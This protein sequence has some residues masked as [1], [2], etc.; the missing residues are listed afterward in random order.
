LAGVTPTAPAGARRLI[1]ILAPL[2]LVV[3]IGAQAMQRIGKP[4]PG[5]PE[6]YLAVG[7]A[8][9]VTHLLL[10]WED[11]SARL[12]RRQLR[13]GTNTL[14][15]SLVVLGILGALNYLVVRHSKRFDLTKNKRYSLSDQTKKVLGG[16]KQDVTV[17]YFQRKAEMP[18]GQDRMKEYT[19][20]S[21]RLKVQFVDPVANPA[22]AQALDVRGPWPTL[23]LEM[24]DKRE[25][26][27][28]D[29]EQDVTNALIK[30][31]RSG[32]KTVCFAEGEG[33]R[34]IEDSGDRGLSALKT[35]L[36]KSQYETKKVVL[37]REK[38]VPADCTVLVV[39]GPEKDLLP[40][41]IDAIRTY[42]KGG[43]K[44]LAMVEPE[45]KEHYPN[46]VALLK[47]WNIEA[48][49]DIVVD[50]S[51]MGQLF[52]TGPITPLASHY[53]SH[54]ITRDFRVMTAFHTARSMKAGTASTPGVTAQNLLETSAASWAESDLTLKEPIE[55]N[56]PNDKK[57]PVQ[58]GAV[59]TVKIAEAS[60]SPSPSPA[61]SPSPE[62]GES[63]KAEGRVAAFG[64]ADFA[65]NAL[66]GFQGN[67]DF[68]LN[69]VAWLAQDVDLISIRPREPDDQR[70]FMTEQQR[71]NV[72]WLSLVL[73]PGLF[74]VLGVSNWWRRR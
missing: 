24:G 17:Y 35:A 59:A 37:L 66:L 19:T 26:A 67:Q 1:D 69:T 39:A 41:A 4:L 62:A 68:A 64:D 50:V 5:K 48:G 20:A 25:K 57:G 38:T 21:P 65:S 42:V 43:G 22:R 44:L 29:S 36:G 32:K 33:E 23:V 34:D 13:Y 28:N 63:A 46:L 60:P 15:L 18:A 3:I 45:M 70:M 73:L 9:M 12:G 74:V 51:G 6:V 14:V 47:E 10:R 30:I 8:L 53:D 54:D 56:E 11:V 71:Q 7:L 31:T 40:Q 49:N 61:A 72:A 27:T 55:L 2:G 16:L 52:G 58:L